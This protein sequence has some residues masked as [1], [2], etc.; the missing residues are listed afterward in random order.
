MEY[1]MY[2]KRD[3]FVEMINCAFAEQGSLLGENFSI[4]H[5]ILAP[6]KVILKIEIV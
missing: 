2:V 5:Q 6:N 3:L 1:I 4:G